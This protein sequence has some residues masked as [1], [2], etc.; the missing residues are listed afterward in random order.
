MGVVD[1]WPDVQFGG[2]EFE[3]GDKEVVKQQAIRQAC[4]NANERKAI[5]ES[6]L[7]LK[8]MPAWRLRLAN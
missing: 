8:L 1:N 7:D 3:Y 2:V 5:Y 6:K 4:D